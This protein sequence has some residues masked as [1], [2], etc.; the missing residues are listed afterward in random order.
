MRVVKPQGD[1]SQ[2]GYRRRLKSPQRDQ[3]HDGKT[4]HGKSPK[5]RS[6]PLGPSFASGTRHQRAY[7]HRHA[8]PD[9]R[10]ETS[11]DQ[12]KISQTKVH[13]TRGGR[14]R[15]HDRFR[16][17][18]RLVDTHQW[19][20]G[21]HLDLAAAVASALAFL[22]AALAAFR[23]ALAAALAS[24]AATLVVNRSLRRTDLPDRSR[25]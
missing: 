14:R 8:S 3:Y 16:W 23:S 5:I 12:N 1:A 6:K 20:P 18:F 17:R 15:R 7:G 10:V 11:S 4:R 25:R 9:H 13:G 2:E 21:D 24:V 22:V 19:R